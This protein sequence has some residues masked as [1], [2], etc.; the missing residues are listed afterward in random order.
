[1]LIIRGV[2]IADGALRYNELAKNLK[3]ISSR[4][5]SKKLKNMANYGIIKKTIIDHSPIKVEYFINRKGNGTIQSNTTNGRL[6]QK[7][8][9]VLNQNN[10]WELYEIRATKIVVSRINK[11]NK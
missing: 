6:E 2:S 9:Q 5:L 4:T 7:M 11:L 8:A 10:N 3:K 1:M